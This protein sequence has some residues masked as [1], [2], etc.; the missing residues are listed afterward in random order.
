M[1]PETNPYFPGAGTRP[2]E[3]A[4]RDEILADVR[5]AIRRNKL[6]APARNF[7]FFGLR[8][9]G[10]TVLLG[11]LRAI[12]E[13][14]GAVTDL[15]EVS[16]NERLSITMITILR[17]VLLRLDRGARV[18]E[19]VKH[20]LRVLKSFVGAIR[21]K[22]HD[23]E[24]SI[25]VD[26]EAG[27]ADSGILT[28]DLAEVFVASGEAAKARESAIVILIDE[29]QNLPADELEALIM[30]VHSTSQRSL[31]FMI[32]GA[33]LPS[34][35]KMAGDAKSYAERLFEYPKINSL[36]KK[37][38]RR[39]LVKPAAASE[40]RFENEAVDAIIEHTK[41]YPYFLQEWGY[42][43]WN[44][45]TGSPI[46]ITDVRKASDL[47]IKR[48]DE[49]FFLSRYERLSNPQ[50]DYLRAMAELGPG[51][52][53]TSDIAEAMKKTQQ[54]LGS[55]RDG[56]I[57]GGMIYSSRWGEVAFTVPL[58]DEFLKRQG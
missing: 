28:R 30:A 45:A 12:A 40:V 39:A 33:G 8:G 7:M 41:G 25:D 37:E 18:S 16:A 52:H 47:A 5:V 51:P 34:I 58:F 14:E 4:G 56:L 55:T 26:S 54:R 43:A 32:I 6:G 1:K 9:V 35:V 17:K 38:A 15:V 29:I 19:Q 27:V 20:S 44:A 46:K 3:L 57:T 42:Q 53:N 31:P 10:K 13:E 24:F 49:N 48:L 36:D 22:Y 23:I 2:P 50:K 11:E 21:V